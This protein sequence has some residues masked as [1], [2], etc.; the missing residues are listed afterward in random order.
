MA[1]VLRFESYQQRGLQMRLAHILIAVLVP[2][3]ASCTE[4]ATSNPDSSGWPSELNMAYVPSEE[5]VERRMTIFNEFA[6][7]L[8]KEIGIP[9]NL[10]R[11]SGYGPTIE[12]LRAKKI[13][14][15][16]NGS[17]TYMI[18]HEKANVQAIISRGTPAGPPC[19]MRREAGFH[20]FPE[21]DGWDP[22]PHRSRTHTP[23][24]DQRTRRYGGDH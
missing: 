24:S 2:V 6:A 14:V 12:A 7:Y 15:S 20:W 23:S 4:S 16:Q 1:L 9:V 22:H 5:D 10:V 18:A 17:F 19:T 3:L 8:S 13:D 11:T 21:D